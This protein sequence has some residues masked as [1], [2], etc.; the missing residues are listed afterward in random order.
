MAY[1]Q[2]KNPDFGKFWS[3]LQRRMLEYYMSMWS[4]LQL[5][6][7]FCGHLVNFI[8]FGIFFPFWSVVP[9]KIWQPMLD[10]FGMDFFAAA[11]GRPD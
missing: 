5:I 8:F 10:G 3:V 1:F 11:T 9:R 7:I 4:I 2:T 6:Y